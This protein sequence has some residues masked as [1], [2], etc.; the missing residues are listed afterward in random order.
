MKVAV[1]TS[2]RGENRARPQTPCPLVQPL[3]RRVPKPTSNPPTI[4]VAA[5]ASIT[6]AAGSEQEAR[7]ERRNDEA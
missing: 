7:D 6:G 5:L 3:A 2:E 1:A 4:R